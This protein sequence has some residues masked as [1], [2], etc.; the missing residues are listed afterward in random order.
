M[1]RVL[2]AA[3]GR[4]D[5]LVDHDRSAHQMGLAAGLLVL[6]QEVDGIGAAETEID[7]ID[8]VRQRGDDGGEILR[9]R[10]EPIAG[11]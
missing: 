6:V 4:Q 10:A 11:S 2:G 9:A 5:G 8:I 1:Q 7:R 3:F